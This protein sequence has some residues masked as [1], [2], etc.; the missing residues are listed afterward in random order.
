MKIQY[1]EDV[2]RKEE[3]EAAAKSAKGF[4]ELE[5]YQEDRKLIREKNMRKKDVLEPQ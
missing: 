2:T 1:I 4:S 3:E 5:K